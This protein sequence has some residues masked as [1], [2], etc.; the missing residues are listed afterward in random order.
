M[1]LFEPTLPVVAGKKKPWDKLP[2]ERQDH[3]EAFETFLG[4]ETR[5]IQ[6]VAT[7]YGWGVPF[8]ADLAKKNNWLARANAFDFKAAE[9][10]MQPELISSKEMM[11]KGAAEEHLALCQSAQRAAAAG[12]TILQKYIQEYEMARLSGEELP[13]KPYLKTEEL[14]KMAEFGIK[15]ERLI[16]GEVTSRTENKQISYDK[17]TDEE[18]AQ[19]SALLEKSENNDD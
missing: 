7:K 9:E 4:S 19:L 6:E 15:Y 8:C 14:V 2:R 3:Y 16:M 18:L 12:F 10:I 13:P 11:L 1:S 5:S 17:L